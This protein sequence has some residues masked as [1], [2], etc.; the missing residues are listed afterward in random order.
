MI[1]RTDQIEL[2]IKE[3]ASSQKDMKREIKCIS[4]TWHEFTAAYMPHIK[5]QAESEKERA[6]LVK[7]LIEKGLLLSIIAVVGF[8][9]SAVWSHVQTLFHITSK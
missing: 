9:C 8:V 2:A 1:D 6:A 3:I 5:R 4:D 7:A